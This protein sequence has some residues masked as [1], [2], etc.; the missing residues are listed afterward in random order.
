MDDITRILSAVAEGDS[1]AANKLLTTVYAELKRIASQKVAHEKSGQTL[2]AT[3]LV[4][5]AYLRLLGADGEPN[6]DSRGHFFAAAAESMRRILVENAR[7]KARLKHGGEFKRVELAGQ[8]IS[9]AAKP[10]DVLAISDALDHSRPK[11]R[12]VVKL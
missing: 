7:R 10:E 1:S 8:D 12:R 3:A 11:I 2:N 9:L 4:H 6:W 5:E